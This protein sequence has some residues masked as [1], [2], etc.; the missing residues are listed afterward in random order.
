MLRSG[1]TLGSVQLMKVLQLVI[2][3]RHAATVRMLERHWREPQPDMVVSFVPH[4]NRAMCESFVNAYPGRPFVTVL[5]DIADYP[6]HFWIERQRQYFGLRLGA[7]GGAGAGTRAH[8][9]SDFSR[10]G[11]DFA[12]AILRGGGGRASGR[13]GAFGIASGF[14]DGACPVRRLRLAGDAGHRGARWMIRSWSCN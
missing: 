8:G 6:P 10:F 4:F 3:S 9:R 7:R 11:N 12:S 14:A 2:R 1:W 13:T 5:T